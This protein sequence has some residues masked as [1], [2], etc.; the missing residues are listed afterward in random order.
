MT[1]VVAQCPSHPVS[2][3]LHAKSANINRFIA[4]LSIAF[5]C[6]VVYHLMNLDSL[7]NPSDQYVVKTIPKVYTEGIDPEDREVFTGFKTSFL[8]AED[9]AFAQSHK[10]ASDTV[11]EQSK[12]Q[13][14]L[15]RVKRMSPFNFNYQDYE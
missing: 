11:W 14:D 9:I 6:T 12:K 13:Q 1:R 8:P 2:V 4:A 3:K 5:T 15:Y 10:G 7:G